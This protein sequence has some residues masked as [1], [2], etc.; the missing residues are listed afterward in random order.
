MTTAGDGFGPI[1]LQNGDDFLSIHD[2]TQTPRDNLWRGNN[3]FSKGTLD[4][5]WYCKILQRRQGLWFHPA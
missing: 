3:T 5:Y 2:A 4:D 1:P